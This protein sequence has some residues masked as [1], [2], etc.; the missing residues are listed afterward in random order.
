MPRDRVSID[1]RVGGVQSFTMVHRQDPTI[2]SPVEARFVELDEPRRI[3]G[4]QAVG[5]ISMTMEVDIAA[6]P[7]GSSVRIR[8][9]PHPAALLEDAKAGWA[10]SFEKLDRA[11]ASRA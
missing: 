2:T 9:H 6:V 4:E 11:L 10:E 1:A 8:Q 3:V 5:P 7:D